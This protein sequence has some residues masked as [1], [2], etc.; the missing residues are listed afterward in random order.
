MAGV[1]RRI[2]FTLIELLVVIAI[3]AILIGLLLPAVQQVRSAA[4][5][6]QCQNNLKE[7]GIALH[8]YHNDKQ[9]FPSGWYSSANPSEALW[10][11]TSFDQILP[12]LEQV[13]LWNQTMT[14]LTADP[15]Y[16]WEAGNPSIA[17]NMKVYICPANPRPIQISAA[18]AGTNTPVSLSSYLGSAGTISGS[19]TPSLDGVLYID[20][21]VKILD[22]RDGTSNTILMGERPS[23]GDLEYGWWPAA[24]GTGWGDGDCVLGARDANLALAFGDSATNIGLQPQSQPGNTTEIDGAHWWSGHTG[25]ANF[26]ACDGSVHF[27]LNSANSILPALSTRAGIGSG[28]PNEPGMFP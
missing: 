25:G 14:W 6:S 19:P 11:T 17:F 15:G 21:H 9:A 28:A 22:I 5:R 4:A 18:A 3:I 10:Y 1:S 12:Y 16:P 2:G 8:L 23:T 13:N 20:S 24:Y 7:I 26:L 27:L